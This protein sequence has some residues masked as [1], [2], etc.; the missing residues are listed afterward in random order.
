MNVSKL[1]HYDSYCNL[2]KEYQNSIKELCLYV[3][4][5]SD[6]WEVYCTERG[7]AILAGIFY[8][9]N[10]LYEYVFCYLK[11]ESDCNSWFGG[12]M[13]NYPDELIKKLKR[14]K[15]PDEE[16]SF[17]GE[18]TKNCLYVQPTE[19]TDNG[20]I[21]HGRVKCE[22]GTEIFDIQKDAFQKNEGTAEAW[23]V[24]YDIGKEKICCGVFF[25]ERDAY[26]FLF[27]LAM[28]K[29]MS[30]EKRWW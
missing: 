1:K 17:S 21:S 20:E 28:R 12:L 25:Q 2:L 11:K 26:D 13:K 24:N 8:D 18:N 5:K 4:K 19:I 15:V 22:D 23:K 10:S 6:F 30:V 9:E 16:Y 29:Q 7:S 27:Y 3:N 14:C